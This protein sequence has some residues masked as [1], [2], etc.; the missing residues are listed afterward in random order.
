M[1]VLWGARG[2][3]AVTELVHPYIKPLLPSF[4]VGLVFPLRLLQI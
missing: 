3:G 1:Q 4:E 2:P